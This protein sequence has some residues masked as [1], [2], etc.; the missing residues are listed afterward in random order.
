LKTS[1]KYIIQNYQLFLTI[2]TVLFL[3]ACNPVGKFRMTNRTVKQ[4]QQGLWIIYTDST[5]TKFLTKGRYKKGLPV[6]KWIYNDTQGKLDRIEVYRGNKIKIKHFHKNGNLA[7]TGKARV[8]NNEAKLHFYYYGIWKYYY[9]NGKLE[10]TALFENGKLMN[11]KFAFRSGS[12]TYD[13]LTAELRSIDLDYVKYRDT[14]V[15][16]EKIYGKNSEQYKNLKNADHKNDSLILVRIDKIMDR[17]GYPPTAKVGE[18][19][20]VIFFIISSTNWQTKEKYIERFRIASLKGDISKKD[21]AYFE[22]KYLVSKEGIQLYGTQ[23]KLSKDNKW[24][25]YPVKDLSNLND[26]R[27]TADLEPVDLLDFS[28]KK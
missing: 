6:G 23:A 15:S 28:E 13:S 4:E 10:K 7:L 18:S 25:H 12:Q 3:S 17:F 20:A 1:N 26:R 5:K 8:V 14:L 21:M 9:E 19:N 22:D 11:E 16:A 2:V 27:K 24:L